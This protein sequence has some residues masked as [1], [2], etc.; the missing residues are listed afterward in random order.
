[1]THKV[2][3]YCN[4]CGRE[5]INPNAPAQRTPIR[6][7]LEAARQEIVLAIAFLGRDNRTSRLPDTIDGLVKRLVKAD[8]AILT[9]LTSTERT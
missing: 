6:Q 4:S 3:A 2:K 8:Q 1:M 9:V 7:E 5:W